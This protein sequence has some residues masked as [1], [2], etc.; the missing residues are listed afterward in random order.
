MKT[1][2]ILGLAVAIAALSGLDGCSESRDARWDRL[3]KE[4]VACAPDTLTDEHRREIAGLLET[5]WTRA[6]VGE[7]F[8]D[9]I[10]LVESE[11]Q[12]FIDA[13]GIEADT[14]LHF[15]ALVGYNSYRRDPRMNLP[16]GIVDHPTLNPDAAIVMFGDDTTGTGNR[17][18]MYYRVPGADSTADSTGADTT[19][20]PPKK[21]RLKEKN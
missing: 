8:D 4:F 5:F 7:V 19:K 12:R 1:T 15:M 17:V 10:A 14:L 16:E 21:G 9:D 11:L 18:Q 13:D 20:A 6:R 3:T 2:V